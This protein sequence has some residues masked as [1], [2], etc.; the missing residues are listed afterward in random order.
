M[1]VLAGARL[2]H[3][4]RRLRSVEP[5]ASTV[6]GRSVAGESVVAGPAVPGGCVPVL[7]AEHVAEPLPDRA[8]S[9]PAGVDAARLPAVRAAAPESGVGSG[10]GG[11]ERL[12]RGCRRG[13]GGAGRTARSGPSVAG[14]PR[15]TVG[16]SPWRCS[17]VLPGRRSSMSSS[18]RGGSSAQSG[19]SGVRTLTG[20]RRPQSMQVL[21]VGG[22][23]DQAVGTQR[24]AV[25]VAGGG[26]ADR[27]AAGTR[28]GSGPGHAVAAKPLPADGPV[29]VD[30]PAGSRGRPARMIALALRRRASLSISRS[31]D[32]DGC[33]GPGSGE[34]LGLG[35]ADAQASR[36]RCPAP[37]AAA[38][39]AA[40]T[41]LRRA[42]SGR[43]R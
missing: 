5:G 30:V 12:G 39:T 43:S 16:R 32:W 19:P 40:A 7:V 33:L 24:F 37:G 2:A 22:V 3:D 41:R 21:L 34:Q 8:A 14:M 6:L 18:S 23:G 31:T 38:D 28:L 9:A 1:S 42:A 27:A 10:A 25:L 35:P 13:L 29:Q 17:T 11:A 26:L 15:T 20:R 4:H 36:W